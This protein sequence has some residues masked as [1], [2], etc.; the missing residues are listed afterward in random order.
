MM[1]DKPVGGIF[2]V[3]VEEAYRWKDSVQSEAEI[4]LWVADGTAQRHAALVHEVRRRAPRPALAAGRRGPLPLAPRHERYL[5]NDAPLARVALV[6]SQQTAWFYAPAAGRPLDDHV[7]GLYHALVEARIPFEMVHDA[8]LDAEALDRYALV[9]LANVAALSDAQCEA[10]RAFVGAGRRPRGD[11]RDLALRRV[12]R[13]ARGLRPRRS[14][15]RLATPA[16][17]TARCGTPT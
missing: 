12:R 8:F 4:R 5:R 17:S 7:A 2:S 3:G 16:A 11:L 10:L 15:R 13:A 1:G 9:V 6:Y 14:V